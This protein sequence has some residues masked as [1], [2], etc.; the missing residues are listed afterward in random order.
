MRFARRT[1]CLS[2][3]LLLILSAPLHAQEPP[4][5]IPLLAFDLHATFPGFPSTQALADSRQLELAELPGRGLGFQAAVHVYPLRWRAITFGIGGELAA[6]RANSTPPEGND[7]LRPVHEK[8]LTASP[9]LS[10]NF[11]SAHGWSYI[12]GGLGVSQWSI[13]PAGRDEPFASDTERLKTLNYGGGARWFARPHLA[14]SFDVR[15]YAISQGPPYLGNPGSPH[16]T[17]L[18]IGAGAS[19]K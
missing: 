16:T 6:S 2:I 18:V 14:F 13:I 8:F 4:P 17:L 19:F 7:T 5:L 9:Q 11:G 1:S 10:F 3:T 12:S 15:F